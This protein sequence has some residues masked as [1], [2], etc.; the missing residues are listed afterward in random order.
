MLPLYTAEEMRR[1][2]RRA[3]GELGIPGA[4]LM[5]NAGRGAAEA[6]RRLLPTL[7]APRRGARVVVVCGKGGNGGDG[8]VV[9]RW[10]ARWSARPEVLLAFPER[11]IGDDAG[12]MLRALK[13][14]GVRP[15][16]VEDEGAAAR[17]LA[18]ADV[19]VDALLGTGA[20]GAPDG[21]VARLIELINASARPVVALDVP[22]GIDADGGEFAGPA[23]S[24]TVTL[25]FAG[26]KRGLVLGPGAGHAGRVEVV[27]IGVPAAEAWRG[28]T[29]FLLERADV[30]RHFPRRPRD[31]HKGTYGH[32]LIVAGSIGKTG[33]AALA[34]MA[35]L[36]SGAGLVTVATPA[37]Q[38]PVVASL[39]L[40]AMTEPLPET[41]ARTLALKAREVVAELAAGRD[42]VALGPGIGLDEETRQAARALVQEL[43]KPMAVDADALSAL[44]GHLDALRGAPAQRC[45]TPHPGEL[46]RLLGVTVAEV[47]RDRI[48]AAREFAT[49]HNV[50][51]VLKGAGSVIG[52]PDGRVVVNPTGNPGL[53]S[54]GTGDVL[55]GMLGALLAR[56]LAAGDALEGAVYLHGLAGDLAAERMGE[57]SLVAGDVIDALPAVF[58]R[59]TDAAG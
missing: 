30:A 26:V 27:P 57:E 32:L 28:V 13:R 42:A 15:W 11:E 35:A 19:V 1:L 38:Q 54:G 3:I 23:V 55:T 36:R 53:A 8:F 46:A 58:G 41:A 37:S 52:H 44:A 25:T 14:T 2:D 16:R 6:I 48:T 47:Q 51:L 22:S 17:R 20:R 34:A 9:A 59:L 39:L 49:R 50:H 10:F 56:G 7:G 4:V 40:E 21:L 18:R 31:A 33:A 5:E 12:E 24:A 45:L 29:T 43:P